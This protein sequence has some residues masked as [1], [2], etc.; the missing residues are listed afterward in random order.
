[1]EDKKKILEGLLALAKETSGQDLWEALKKIE[2]SIQGSLE[3]VESF[4]DLLVDMMA[5]EAEEDDEKFLEAAPQV[6]KKKCLEA[7][8]GDHVIK[9]MGLDFCKSISIDNTSTKGAKKKSKVEDYR[10]SP[11]ELALI[12]KYSNVDLTADDV[13]VFTLTSADQEVDRSADQFT[14]KALKEMAEMSPDKPYLMNHDWEVNSVVGK[15]FDA[16]AGKTLTQKVYVPDTEKNKDFI[17]GMLNGTLNKVSVGFSISPKEYICSSCQKSLY[18]MECSHYPGGKDKEGKPVIGI[19]K[20][21]KDYYEISNV[22]VPA[23]RNAG[24]RRE[25]KDFDPLEEDETKRTCGNEE[26]VDRISEEID[27]L[28]EDPV[29]ENQEPEVKEVADEEIKSED[30]VQEEV[31]DAPQE[32]D[33]SLKAFKELATLLA[34]EVAAPLKELVAELK[35]TLKEKEEAAKSVEDESTEEIARK[36]AATSV[37]TSS[38]EASPKKA[39]SWQEQV[40]NAVN[41]SAQ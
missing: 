11:E 1:M 25:E 23:Q 37:S 33:A 22:A 35:A 6:A 19:I 24:I 41:K 3:E 27:P 17:T 13:Y 14:A 18:S 21:V 28:G 29:S 2:E 20:G 5:E 8:T 16:K 31:K 39:L 9:R 7:P 10:P 40:F 38:P 26:P 12:N 32:E 34:A 15:I 4:E 30:A 36:L